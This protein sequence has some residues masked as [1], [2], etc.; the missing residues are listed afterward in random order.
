MKLLADEC[1]ER[2]IVSYLKEN[3]FDIITVAEL[4]PG[5]SDDK[6]IELANKMKSILITADKDFGELIYRQ[7]KITFGIILVRLHGLTRK[8]KVE[9]IAKTLNEH[10]DKL[11]GSFT[12]IE[13][14]QIRIREASN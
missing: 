12:V 4:A 6:V 11:L 7:R 10:K 1:I 8:K 14:I 13:P 5:A 2:S 9:I 3:G